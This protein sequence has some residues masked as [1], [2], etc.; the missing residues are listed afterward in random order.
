MA[1]M[2]CWFL[3]PIVLAQTAN[4]ISVHMLAEINQY[5]L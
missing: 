1:L 3:L 5:D 4:S 2:P